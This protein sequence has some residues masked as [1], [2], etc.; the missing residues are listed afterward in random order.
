MEKTSKEEKR[1]MLYDLIEHPEKYSNEEINELLSDE[2]VRGDYELLTEIKHTLINKTT[3]ILM[4]TRN[5]TVSLVIIMVI[6][7]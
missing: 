2:E 4:L 3:R 1:M 7:G 6:T 5:G